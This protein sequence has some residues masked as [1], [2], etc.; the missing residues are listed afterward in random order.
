MQFIR[1]IAALLLALFC[2]AGALSAQTTPPVAVAVGELFRRNSSTPAQAQEFTNRF[3]QFLDNLP[4]DTA[5]AALAGT[6]EQFMQALINQGLLKSDITTTATLRARLSAKGIDVEKL[7]LRGDGILGAISLSNGEGS[8]FVLQGA[9]PISAMEAKS[10][11]RAFFDAAGNARRANRFAFLFFLERNSF[12]DLIGLRDNPAVKPVS[13]ASIDLYT[14][15]PMTQPFNLTHIIHPPVVWA[16]EEEND[17]SPL[18]SAS[19]IASQLNQMPVGKRTLRIHGNV[20]AFFDRDNWWRGER[21]FKTYTDVLKDG[22]GQVIYSPDGKPYLFPDLTEWAQKTRER[23][24]PWLAQL[25]QLTTVDTINLDFEDPKVYWWDIAGQ[26]W[27]NVARR[28]RPFDPL[29]ADPRFNPLLGAL[30]ITAADV[31]RTNDFDQ[32]YM[33]NWGWNSPKQLR[34]DNYMAKYVSVAVD[35]AVFEPMRRHFPNAYG[36]NYDFFMSVNTF[37]NGYTATPEWDTLGLENHIDR[38]LPS[39]S[40]YGRAVCNQWGTPIQA[41]VPIPCGETLFRPSAQSYYTP[42]NAIWFN[43]S[44]ADSHYLA[45]KMEKRPWVATPTWA[46]GMFG[47][48][49]AGDGTQLITYNQDTLMFHGGS[50]MGERMAEVWYRAA[51]DSALLNIWNGSGGYTTPDDEHFAEKALDEINEVMGFSDR[52][53]LSETWV[54]F[55]NAP[56]SISPKQTDPLRDILVWG[57]RANGR[58]I[59]RVV[60]DLPAGVDRSTTV[61]NNGSTGQPVRIVLG[62]SM[63]RI[64]NARILYPSKQTSQMGFWVVQDNPYL[65]T[66]LGGQVRGDATGDGKVTG[67]DYTILTINLNKPN[68]DLRADFNFDGKVTGADYTIWAA[69]FR[70]GN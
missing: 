42:F 43:F 68:P 38:T 37:P 6:R 67:A 5:Y 57:V 62:S 50:D 33:G 39:P 65:G 7:D 14:W 56:F 1:G 22:S 69:N 40:I 25:K 35:H 11:L 63:V 20:H 70:S 8:L 44:Q 4:F 2:S 24:D 58:N 41:D 46:S 48:G 13:P 28:S 53:L 26:F 10:R 18:R 54:E 17:N 19:E 12:L 60:L 66:L 31:L 49:Q 52:R 55:N 47:P 32:N 16:L 15:E 36:T 9:T 23:L 27:D 45:S 64:P 3:F 34:W 21:N 29:F 51:A 59:Y 30:G 61:L